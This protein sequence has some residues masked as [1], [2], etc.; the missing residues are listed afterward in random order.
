[1]NLSLRT[2]LILALLLGLLLPASINGYF[3]LDRQL[4]KAEADLH[5]D[6]ARIADVL[7]LG[8]QEPLWNLSPEAGRP[9][10]QS[11]MSD[12]RVVRISVN[13]AT[14]GRFLSADR[15]DRVTG[16]LFKLSR[17]VSKQGNNIGTISVELDDGRVVAQIHANQRIYLIAVALQVAISMGL[18]LFLLESRLL[19]PVNR[20][21]RQS[22][23]LAQQDLSE[24]FEWQR[25]D[26]LG[27]LGR[28]LEHT[29]RSLRQLIQTL[30]QKNLQLEADLLSRRQIE[31]ALRASEDRYR[32]LV[33]NT[34]VIPW[35][36]HPEAWSFT[37]VGPQAEGLLGYPL[38]SWYQENFLVNVL[39]PDDRHLL[40]PVFSEFTQT[41]HSQIECRFI[42]AEG[43]V[44]WV[45]L[46]ASATVNE[47]GSKH[48]QGYLV[49]IS[50]RRHTAQELENYRNHL[51]EAIEA[52][53]RAM[54]T[55]QHESDA[56]SWSISHDLRTP[57]RTIDGF[58][59]VLQED[60]GEKLDVNA[61][62]YLARIRTA[63]LNMSMLIEDLI[64]LTRISRSEVRRQEVDV[65]ALAHDV[66]EELHAL[67]PTRQIQ[68]LVRPGLHAW[69][70]P[71]L[72]R[73]VLH[74][75]LHNAWK[76]TATRDHAEI[77][78]GMNPTGGQPVFYVRDNG[79]GFDMTQAGK[80][81]TPFHRLHG[82]GDAAGNG[83][84]LAIAQRAIHRHDGRIWA[85]SKVNEGTTIFFTVPDLRREP[86]AR[87][88]ALLP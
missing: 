69:A 43:Q 53:T 64:A 31:L 84:G 73:V 38:A 65:T 25:N 76:F 36:A 44:V 47:D 66:I 79:L 72:L 14:L 27:R 60:Y 11:F 10:L 48:L 18:I 20:L 87:E 9:L 41:R 77:E 45:W 8:M 71:R 86:G 22:L 80:L 88:F 16:H 33:E 61:R 78:F 75:L 13:D 70:D 3:S 82:P 52:R 12:E 5:A 39:H 26:E 34:Q 28:N 62:N 40:Y 21:T 24:S 67:E 81:F 74:N 85:R 83:I 15:P 7:A 54:A 23:Q 2:A 63:V 1:M 58:S 29:R 6:H 19:R 51:E 32:R 37:Y 35:D 4:A 50:A 17:I 30:E 68:L 42:G 55:V 46:A 49:D 56:L 59:Q 57:L